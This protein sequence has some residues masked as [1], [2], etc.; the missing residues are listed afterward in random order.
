MSGVPE[1]AVSN[2]RF[3]AGGAGQ[4]EKA[5]GL[6]DTGMLT[7]MLSF[8]DGEHGLYVIGSPPV[9]FRLLEERFMSN[10]I[11]FRFTG[12]PGQTNVVEGSFDLLNWIPL[13]TNVSGADPVEF[14][15]PE[16]WLFPRRY[17]RVRRQ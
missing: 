12:P 1:V 5:T 4:D 14:I 9:Y 7:Y 3:T 2:I 8:A 6:S 17:Y 16:T 11:A 15:D 10:H 13:G